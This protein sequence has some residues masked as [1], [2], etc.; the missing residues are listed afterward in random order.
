MS[1]N[2]GQDQ[3][4]I[5]DA[6]SLTESMASSSASTATDLESSVPSVR[7]RKKKRTHK[8]IHFH[9]RGVRAAIEE[10]GDDLE[11][12]EFDENLPLSLNNEPGRTECS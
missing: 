8:S 12:E 1:A 3:L 2:D 10:E 6:G 11:D 5:G 7:K 9:V 4:A